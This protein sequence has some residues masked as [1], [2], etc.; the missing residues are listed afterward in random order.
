MVG[1]AVTAAAAATAAAAKAV[2]TS[3]AAAAVVTPAP[4]KPDARGVADYIMS[5]GSSVFRASPHP[6]ADPA[7]TA[8]ATAAATASAGKLTTIA[9]PAA[10]AVLAAHSERGHD[11]IAPVAARSGKGAKKEEIMPPDDGG[12]GAPQDEG[13]AEVAKPAGTGSSSGSDRDDGVAPSRDGGRAKPA[14]TSSA[15]VSRPDGAEGRYAHVRASP[16]S[17]S[18]WLKEVRICHV[19]PG[20][21]GGGRKSRR[22]G[23]RTGVG[24]GLKRYAQTAMEKQA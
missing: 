18:E 15:G 2:A 21:G 22:Y 24:L 1:A 9:A 8:S 13:G 20:G 17:L 5:N 4:A 23:R 7:T 6:V 11:E 16:P 3:T 12:C 19:F 10:E 14:S